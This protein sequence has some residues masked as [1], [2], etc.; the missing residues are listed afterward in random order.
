[1]SSGNVEKAS[2]QRFS[3]SEKFQIVV[4]IHIVIRII[5]PKKTAKIFLHS[6]CANTLGL[7]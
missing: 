7:G 6:G 2:W 3:G 4:K 1:M 5:P